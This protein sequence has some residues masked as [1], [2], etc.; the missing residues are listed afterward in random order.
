MKKKRSAEEES[1]VCL[2]KEKKNS[3]KDV[4]EKSDRGNKI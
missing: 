4:T 1:Q 3:A 2:K